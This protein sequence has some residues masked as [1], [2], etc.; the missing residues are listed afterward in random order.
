MSIEVWISFVFASL[1]LCFSPGPTVFLVMGQSLNHGKKS[2]V[3]LVTGVLS[4]DLVAMSLSF[5]GLG[6]LLAT[7][8]MLFNVFKLVAAA[9]LFYIGIKAWTTKINDEKCKTMSTKKG[10]IFKDA[11][12][13]TAFNPKGIIFFSAFFPLFIDPKKEI[14][15]QMTIIAISFLL[16][17][18]ASTT[19]YSTFSG[20]LGS[21]A[22]SPKFQSTF[23]KATGTMLMG[24]GAVT[25][26]VQK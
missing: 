26:S 11:F 25:A 22:K 6:V 21:K 18:V 19:L 15:P 24:A 4:G 13:V 9:Y 16:V 5:A 14:A 23:N 20:Y 2:V 17:S 3:P 8:A 12:L 7:S 10:K 1:I